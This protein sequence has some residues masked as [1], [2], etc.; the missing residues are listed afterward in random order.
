MSLIW[1]KCIFTF[2]LHF[3]FMIFTWY[4]FPNM[5]EYI[6]I[7]MRAWEDE[8]FL[9]FGFSLDILGFQVLNVA[10]YLKTLKQLSMHKRK[11]NR[12]VIRKK[13]EEYVQHVYEVYL[14][15]NGLWLNISWIFFSLAFKIWL[16]N[17]CS[18]ALNFLSS[19]SLRKYREIECSKSSSSYFL[20]LVD[21]VI[22]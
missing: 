19:P 4:D 11:V 8:V 1:K 21:L 16:M 14:W 18:K 12:S 13:K 5:L 7:S 10:K 9:F 15:S 22:G 6:L 17:K 2:L 3:F 20:T